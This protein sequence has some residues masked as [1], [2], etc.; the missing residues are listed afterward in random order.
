M[1]RIKS[2]KLCECGCGQY[3]YLAPHTD[4]SKQWIRGQPLRFL[5]GHNGAANGRR[6]RTSHGH[7]AERTMSRTYRSWMS[8]RDRCTNPN[9]KRWEDY[10]GRGIKV[11][12]RWLDSFEAFLA[13]MG[14]RP[15]GKTLDRYPDVNG[16]YEPGNCRWAT[17][18][19]Q[20]AN[21]RDSRTQS[22]L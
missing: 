22:S 6:A 12:E 20:R 18:K 8:M 16:D 3:T 7:A 14:E 2:S 9:Y 10:G 11:C 4:R 5:N 13:D 17:L 15:P 19:E 1:A 21:R